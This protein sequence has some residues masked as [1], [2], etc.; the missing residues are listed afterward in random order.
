MKSRFQKIALAMVM[1]ALLAMADGLSASLSVPANMFRAAAGSWTPASGALDFTPDAERARTHAAAANSGDLRQIN[2][3]LRFTA[4]SPD[5]GVE[6]QELRGTFWRARLRVPPNAPPGEIRFTVY[7]ADQP[8]TEQT[9]SFILR[10]FPSEEALQADLPSAAQRLLGISPWAVALA[11]LPMAVFFGFLV[12][13]AMGEEED[14]LIARGIGPIYRLARRKDG[15]EI[16]FGLGARQGVGEG[17]ELAVLAPDGR[18][19]GALRA[20]QVGPASSTSSLDLA[21]DIGS[22]YF[23]ALAGAKLP[24]PL[25]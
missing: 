12:F 17:D 21:A 23:V 13:R 3:Y 15:W 14:A 2:E 22:G 4:T 18:V 6:F 20:L 5:M 19:V 11:A 9:P 1:L 8:P 16:T 7:V 25:R 10:V 24:A